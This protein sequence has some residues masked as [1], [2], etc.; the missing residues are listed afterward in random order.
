MSL[1]SLLFGNTVVHINNYYT[2]NDYEAE[3]IIL[4]TEH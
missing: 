1:H 3:R 2:V 4:S